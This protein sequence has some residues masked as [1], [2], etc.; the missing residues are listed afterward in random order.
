MK[1]FLNKSRS[2]HYEVYGLFHCLLKA[3]YY[4]KCFFLTDELWMSSCALFPRRS[5]H[6]ALK[7]HRLRLRHLTPHSSRHLRAVNAICD[8]TRLSYE[9]HSFGHLSNGRHPTHSFRHLYKSG[10]HLGRTVAVICYL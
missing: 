10:R 7:R 6:L 9:S 5:R 3:V 8:S 4:I 2:L 1:G